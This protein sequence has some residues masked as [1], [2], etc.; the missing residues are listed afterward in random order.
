MA[1]VAA[2]ALMSHPSLM[3]F[4]GHISPS[5]KVLV[6]V[7]SGMVNDIVTSIK[8]IRMFLGKPFILFILN[9]LPFPIVSN[10]HTVN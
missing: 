6:S 4:R 10:L 1:K 9:I 7:I 3:C 8:K 5:L 2:A